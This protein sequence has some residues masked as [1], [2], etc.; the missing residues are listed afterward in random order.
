MNNIPL[1]ICEEMGEIHEYIE[2]KESLRMGLCPDCK[3][4]LEDIGCDELY[5]N[6]CKLIFQP[7]LTPYNLDFDEI[8]W[9]E[10]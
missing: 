9:P 5:C 3:I 8:D 2:E 6:N 4:K 10:G 7:L 1:Q